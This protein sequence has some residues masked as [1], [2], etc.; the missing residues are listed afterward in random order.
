[1]YN[2]PSRKVEVGS[3]QSPVT[4]EVFHPQWRTG[5]FWVG[6]VVAVEQPPLQGCRAL[7]SLEEDTAPGGAWLVTRLHV[8]L[9]HPWVGDCD[10]E[11]AQQP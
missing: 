3:P 10:G 11:W 2:V 6:C 4:H 8:N 9:S 7:G 1:M 5:C